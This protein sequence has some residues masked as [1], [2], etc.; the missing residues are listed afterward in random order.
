MNPNNLANSP[1]TERKAVCIWKRGCS[2]CQRR[3]EQLASEDTCP[4]WF[5][6]PLCKSRWIFAL[7]VHMDIENFLGMSEAERA[8]MLSD[9]GLLGVDVLLK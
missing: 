3:V 7:H 6:C 9:K 1:N 2:H 5:R 8:E 4:K